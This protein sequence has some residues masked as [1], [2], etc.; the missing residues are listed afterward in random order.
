[1]KEKRG[2]R[3]II[4]YCL[5]GIRMGGV[6]VDKLAALVVEDNSDAAYIF[7]QALQAAGFEV[8][9]ANTG[10]KALTMLSATAPDLVILDIALPDVSG[11]DVLEIIRSDSHLSKTRVIMT[12]AF[13]RL[14]QKLHVGADLMLL[15]PVSYVKLRDLSRKLVA[16]AT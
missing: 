5:E 12:T 3:V 7:D 14:A 6:V 10:Q 16:S 4:P 11:I 15:K 1:M 13:P 2:D 8:E 9:V